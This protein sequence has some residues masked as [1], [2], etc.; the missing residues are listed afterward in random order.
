MD[1][2]LQ[3]DKSFTYKGKSYSIDFS[4]LIRRSLFFSEKLNEFKNEQN[5]E[6]C[7]T[8]VGITE[9]AIQC[10][11]SFCQFEQNENHITNSN[12]LSI[13]QLAIEYNVPGLIK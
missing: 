4:L 9:D 2:F 11:I 1:T 13:R 5:I 8:R 6:I 10:F 7:D 12:V 3:K